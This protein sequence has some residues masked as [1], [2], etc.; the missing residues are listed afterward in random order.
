MLKQFKKEF[1]RSNITFDQRLLIAVSGGVDSMVLWDLMYKAKKFHGI[2]HI[3]YM[4]RGEESDQDELL[5]KQLAEE[6]GI[7]FYSI[8]TNTE[9]FAKENKLSLQMAARK[10]RYDFFEKVMKKN[11]FDVLTTAHHLEDNFET[12]LINLNRGT[13]LRGLKGINS[14]KEKFRPLLS[15]TKSEIRNYAK[16]NEVRFREDKSNL[17]TKYERNWFR[18]KVIVPWKE[19]NPEL[20]QRMK[21]NFERLQ[22]ANEIVED[23]LMG[24]AKELEKQKS[25][26]YLKISAI[27][28]LEKPALVLHYLLHPFGFNMH[29]VQKIMKCLHKKRVGKVFYADDYN[30]QLDRTKVFI[31]EGKLEEKLDEHWLI[32]EICKLKTPIYLRAKRKEKFNIKFNKSKKKELF[33]SKKLQFPLIL[34]KWKDGDKIKPLGM[35][36]QK[37]V[38]DILIDE[39]IP[40]KKKSD[41]YVLISGEE[42]VWLIGIKTSEEFKVTKETQ[43]A[44]QFTTKT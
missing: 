36:G 25:N 10:I 31:S 12:F 26:G 42:I 2:A 44:I 40:L 3:N 17:D 30:L 32:D 7:P 28:A 15:F 21:F 11:R 35:K 18:H 41:V 4:L 20:L 8:K 27:L 33:D 9:Q 23:Y 24:K 1:V 14:D 22:E 5:V 38:S 39:K 34:R 37:K 16:E 19:L 43:T 29:Q 6:R 13:S